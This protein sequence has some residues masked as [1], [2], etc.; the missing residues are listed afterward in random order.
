P[1]REPD[2]PFG[3]E[4]IFEFHDGVCEALLDELARQHQQTQVLDVLD[5]VDRFIAER[6]GQTSQFAGLIVLPDDAPA[7]DQAV[8]FDPLALAFARTGSRV[9][10]HLGL[11]DE[12]A[13]RWEAFVQRYETRAATTP[14]AGAA[15][16]RTVEDFVVLQLTGAG[17]NEM[18]L[19]ARAEAVRELEARLKS[20][21]A[22]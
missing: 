18:R 21:E 16:L 5:A 1:K 19:K 22:E 20:A 6:S 10:R 13:E 9:L 3:D 14:P 4:E 12:Q 11:R 8:K 2:E 15:D 17:M 7:H